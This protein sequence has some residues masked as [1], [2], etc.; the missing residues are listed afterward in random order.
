MDFIKNIYQKAESYFVNRANESTL[1]VAAVSKG[2]QSTSSQLNY[3]AESM[4]SKSL[5]D[6]Q[7]AIMLAT[8]RE[9]PQ[10]AD[11]SS[12]Y[13]NLLLDNHLSSV[14]DSRI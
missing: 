4:M 6:W 10:F 12:L 14:V 9:E 7:S 2:V 8:D 1:R 5:K 13:S 11:L 3:Q